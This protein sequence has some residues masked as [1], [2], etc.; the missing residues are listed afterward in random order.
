MRVLLLIRSLDVGGAERQVVDLAKG[1]QRRGHEV[2]VATFYQA[3]ALAEELDGEGVRRIALGKRG[4]WDVLPFLMRLRRLLVCER[5]DVL[6][7]YLGIP[8]TLSALL[9]RTITGV[10]LIWGVR[11]S[12]VD[13]RR[14]DS[15]VRLAFFLECRLSHIP[16]LIIANSVAGKKYH[17]GKGFPSDN[18][19]V[20]PN[21]IDTDRFVPDPGARTKFRSEWKIED[22]E[23]LIGLV[24]R[25]DPM[26]DHANFLKAAAIVRKQ[27]LDVRFACIGDGAP[28][29]RA[30]LKDM[31]SELGL[32]EALIWMGVQTDI[33]AVFNGLDIA[34]SSSYSEGFSNVIAEAMACCIP[35][36]VTDVG[37]SAALV[38]DTGIVVPARCPQAL[39]DGCLRKLADL[40]T[41]RRQNEERARQRIVENF[42]VEKMVSA[43]EKVLVDLVK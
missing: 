23:I 27:R 29:Q 16:D 17:A 42:S 37:D 32:A 12:N 34:C 30:I 33:N 25:L 6:Y 4:R 5:P 14:Y 41:A 21:G 18:L 2:L 7:S 8:N 1:L 3:G 19:I 20:I 35:C 15:F 9:V 38:G 13:L 39:A 10:R 24:A 43:T 28:Q 22:N 26:K 31:A 36:V 40:Q 11:A